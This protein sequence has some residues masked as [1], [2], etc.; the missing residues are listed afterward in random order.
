MPPLN[1]LIKPASG[2]CN[3]RCS[4]CFYADETA[5]R[6]V[7]DYG[8]MAEDTLEILIE[9]ALEK[10]EYKCTFG[11]QG[12][13][14]TLRGLD[15]YRRA[16]ELEKKYNRMNL[17][18]ENALQTNGLLIDDE[19]ARFL[20]ENKFLVGLSV[21]GCASVHNKNRVDAKGEGTL[22]RVLEAAERLKKYKCDFNVL[23]VVTDDTA[24]KIDLIYDFFARHDLR[25]Q[26]YIPCLDA[27]G[28]E[29]SR[30][31]ERG[32]A[33]FLKK[34]FDRWA[35]DVLN[36]RFIYIRQFENYVGMLLGRPAESCGMMGCCSVQYAVE[37]D[38]GVYPCDFYVLDE[39]RLGSLKDQSFEVIDQKRREMRFIELS[40]EK[41]G[42]CL[43]CPW[44]PLCR[45]GC[46]RDRD[47]G[48]GRLNRSRL[49]G[50]YQEFFPYA[51]P[52]LEEI[53]RRAAQ[54]K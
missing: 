10:A 22:R 17:L 47:D 46:R 25:W 18:I 39:Y 12:G 2:R 24:Q 13:E 45:G 19:W 32:Y 6:A 54:R 3:M 15:F 31:T 51:L 50:A 8:M 48:N 33:L 35:D 37:A 26:Q 20:A 36:G 34:L 11:F 23:T 29:N 40:A 27:F 52:R 28:E 7:K 21:D 9:K 5:R 4:Y 41:E 38:G 43:G 49:C 1:L 42:E 44:Y 30:L 16:A 53:A 14:P